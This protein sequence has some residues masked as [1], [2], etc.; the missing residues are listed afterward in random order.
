MTMTTPPPLRSRLASA[1]RQRG[2]VGAALIVALVGSVVALVHRPGP[3]SYILPT[4]LTLEA[5]SELTGQRA[6]SG[7]G[8]NGSSSYRK[9]RLEDGSWLHLEGLYVDEELSEF[10]SPPGDATFTVETIEVPVDASKKTMT[11]ARRPTV[12]ADVTVHCMRYVLSAD[13]VAPGDD[14]ALDAYVDRLRDHVSQWYVD[15]PEDPCRNRP[16]PSLR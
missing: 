6:V 1:Q 4:P 12:L 15:A 10:V 5:A 2:L 7:G 16:T 8:F 9:A 13:G 14:A 11:Y 3:V